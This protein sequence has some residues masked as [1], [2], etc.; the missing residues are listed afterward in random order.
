[1]GIKSP[2]DWKEQLGQA[3][4][5]QRERAREEANAAFKEL[6]SIEEVEGLSTHGPQANDEESGDSN[7]IYALEEPV[8]TIPPS[9]MPT[10]VQVPGQG[11]MATPTVPFP[12]PVNQPFKPRMMV[13][14]RRNQA[15]KAE[16]NGCI[17][18][19][20][21]PLTQEQQ[22]MVAMIYLAEQ[23]YA[24]IERRRERK[25]FFFNQ[26]VTVVIGI[27]GIVGGSL[28]IRNG[29]NA[30]SERDQRR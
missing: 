30:A 26:W 27:L 4:K 28:A 9:A 15:Q 25:L 6:S 11:V 5:T 29:F 22:E 19:P 21:V 13:D 1:M 8:M 2:K 23:Y 16:S 7:L 24:A 18:A 10:T 17:P 3:K 20:P 14:D 12:D